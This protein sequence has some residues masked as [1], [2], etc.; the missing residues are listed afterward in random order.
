MHFPSFVHYAKARPYEATMSSALTT[1]VNTE[2]SVQFRNA[3]MDP[4][5][6]LST[7]PAIKNNDCRYI[8]QLNLVLLLMYKR[9]F[10]IFTGSTLGSVFAPIDGTRLDFK[11][12][13]DVTQLK[14]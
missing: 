3:D 6:Q 4:S 2:L 5:V 1:L 12:C 10:F 13:V 9:Y 8:Q 7:D 11:M 14:Q